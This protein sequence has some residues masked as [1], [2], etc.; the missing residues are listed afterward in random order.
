M[1]YL[2]YCKT[3]E[4]HIFSSALRRTSKAAGIQVKAKS[5]KK[6]KKHKHHTTAL[7]TIAYRQTR[8]TV[9]S[10][11]NSLYSVSVIIMNLIEIIIMMNN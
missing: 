3:N 11:L 8:G 5:I 10:P 2:K 1:S 4:S 9:T 7:L 6:K